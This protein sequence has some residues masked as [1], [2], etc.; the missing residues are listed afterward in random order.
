MFLHNHL[1]HRLLTILPSHPAVTIVSATAI[2]TQTENGVTD[3]DRL[4]IAAPVAIQKRIL[5]RAAEAIE[6]ANAKTATET[7]ETVETIEDG[8]EIA[9]TAQAAEIVGNVKIVDLAVWK[10]RGSP[11]IV[12]LL[13]VSEICSTTVENDVQNVSRSVVAL[14]KVGEKQDRVRVRRRK[15]RESLRQIS[16]T[17]YPSS[18]ERDVKQIGTSSLQAMRMSQ[19]NKPSSRACFHCQVLRDNSQWTQRSSR[20][21]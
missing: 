13:D 1:G 9:V 3:Q 19:L 18:S 2:E 14:R 4:I 15:R 17:P 20:R 8:T 21:S 12:P 11:I 5:T 10:L 7:Q 6:S 16:Q